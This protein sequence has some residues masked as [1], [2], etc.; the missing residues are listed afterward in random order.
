MS[1]N[2]DSLTKYFSNCSNYFNWPEIDVFAKTWF[3]RTS[4]TYS[5]LF[6]Y[7]GLSFGFVLVFVCLF[8]FNKRQNGWTDQVQ[9]FFGSLTQGMSQN[10]EKIIVN[11]IDAR[12]LA[13][14]YIT[15]W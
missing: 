4:H 11:G 7:I 3:V 13:F 9:S 1:Q 14:F 8:V 12:K 6:I 10:E 15:Q 2:G 5:P